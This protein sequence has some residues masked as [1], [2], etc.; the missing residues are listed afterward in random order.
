MAGADRGAAVTDFPAL[1]EWDLYVKCRTCGAAR[2]VPC[3]SISGT[4]V[5][6]RPDGHSTPLLLPHTGRKMRAG[7]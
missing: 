2:A 3:R 1:V 6:G 4:I 5:G 7:R